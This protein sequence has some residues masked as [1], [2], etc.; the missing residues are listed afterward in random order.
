MP[1]VRKFAQEF[2]NEMD[3]R[4]LP[5]APQGHGFVHRGEAVAVSLKDSFY[6]GCY[7]EVMDRGC[8]LQQFRARAGAFD[9]NAIALAIRGVADA[10]LAPAPAQAAAPSIQEHNQHL[11]DNLVTLTSAGPGS[12]VSIKPSRQTKG[13]VRVQLPEVELDPASVMHLF[14]LVQHALPP[15]LRRDSDLPAYMT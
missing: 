3:L 6:T 12:A 4:E 1:R 5:Q 7:V 9:W 11:A 13:R 15:A 2:L 10:R 8:V 14:G